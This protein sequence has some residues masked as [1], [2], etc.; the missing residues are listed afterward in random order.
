MPDKM[1]VKNVIGGDRLQHWLLGGGEGYC[2]VEEN[3]ITEK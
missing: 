1:K 3:Y 2:V